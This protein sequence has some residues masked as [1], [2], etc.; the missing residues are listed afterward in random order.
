MAIEK[1][2]A[3][4]SLGL[5]VMFVAQMVSIVIFLMHPTYD[6]DPSSMIREF[7]SISA[8][9]GLIL[10]GLSFLLSRKYGSRLNGSVIIAGGIVTLF[11]MYYVNS[12]LPKIAITYLVPEFTVVP[13]MFM[14][15]SIPIIV[16]GAL[17]FRI[18]PR[19]KRDYFFDR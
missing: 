16:I 15:I 2:V 1:W 6:I 13:T 14:A 7:I 11:G 5:F 12:L 19:P 9:P 8:A 4:A 3:F 10:A 17:L 18:K